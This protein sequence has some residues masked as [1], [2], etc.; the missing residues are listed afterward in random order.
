L[1]GA[2]IPLHPVKIAN[3]FIAQLEFLELNFKKAQF[4]RFS[5]ACLEFRHFRKLT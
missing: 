3:F 1:I 4:T 2:A 5:A